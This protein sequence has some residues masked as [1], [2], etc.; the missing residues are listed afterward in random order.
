MHRSLELRPAQQLALTPQIVQ[1]IRLLQLSAAELEHEIEEELARNPFLE[2]ALP[3]A[4]GASA[5][6]E[7]TSSGEASPSPLAAATDE[8]WTDEPWTGGA[9]RDADDEPPAEPCAEHTSLRE[10][11]REQLAGSRLQKADRMLVE[12]VID[13]LDDD[14]Y[15][16]LSA[17]ELLRVVPAR[18]G[19]NAA[20][21]EIAVRYVQSL[22]PAGV[23]ARSPAECLSLQLERQ[24]LDNDADASLRALALRIVRDHLD[25][26]ALHDA[27]R[28]AQALGCDLESIRRANVLIRRLNPRPG[29]PFGAAQA[30]YVIAD[31]IVRKIGGRW[32]ARINPQAVPTLRI[33]HLY[34]EALQ[35]S[36]DTGGPLVQYLQQARWLVRNVQQRFVTIGRVAQAIVDR[37]RLYLELGELAMKPLVLRDIARELGL[38]PSTVSRAS[39]NKY[40]QTPAGMIELKRFF[41]A[42]AS[43]GSGACSSTAIRALIRELVAA[44]DPRDP[45]S[46]VQITRLLASRGITVARRTVAKY[47]ATLRIA[48]VESRRLMVEGDGR[49][50]AARPIASLASA[51]RTALQQAAE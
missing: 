45:L 22:D 7:E 4:A 20:D 51:R 32:I 8:T 47:R 24:P 3:P 28:L 17:D 36:R 29:A 33:N 13:S 46:D 34:A 41:A 50:A 5:P 25:L 23:A 18:L 39:N 35:R 10:H 9:R 40:A 11:L 14:G 19:A 42:Q 12:G 6:Q 27:P 30:P 1:A 44:E 21:V 16:R 26:L 37:Q 2:R 48:P 15:L 43:Q 49:L 38:H 31:V